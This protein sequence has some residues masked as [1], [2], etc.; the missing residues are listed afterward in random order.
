MRSLL[1]IV[2]IIIIYGSLYPF[3]FV[4]TDPAQIDW[5]DWG[6]QVRQRTTNGD[7]LSNFLTFVP[8]G[9]FAFA[10][11]A[12]RPVGYFR[13]VLVILFWGAVLAFAMQIVQ[14]YT[15]TRI[16]SVGD[17]LINILGICAGVAIAVGVQLWLKRN[18]QYA[19]SWPKIISVPLVLAVGWMAYQLFPFVPRFELISFK[20]NLEPLIGSPTWVWHEWLFQSVMWY[21]FIVFLQWTRGFDAKFPRLLLV[22]SLLL[23]S[24][25]VIAYNPID[26]TDLMAALSALLAYRLWPCFY[27]NYRHLLLI[28]V[29]IF[30]REMYPFNYSMN[31]AKFNLVPF[32]YYLIGSM[33][34]N[35]QSILEKLFAYGS[36]IFVAMEVLGHRIKAIVIC[37]LFILCIELL[38]LALVH[39]RADITDLLM[40]VAIGYAFQQLRETRMV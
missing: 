19:L 28:C 22:V 40:I 30:I 21:C 2:I 27:W 26:I 35:T 13:K 20:Q 36:L 16:P 10:S 3:H 37:L 11:Q 4:W 25:I 31:A 33:W 14:F 9:Y 7:V 23:V 15:P 24:K 5:L 18:P 29:A 32:S 12:T 34:V 6:M 1:W 38:Q 17:A 8:L 39:Q